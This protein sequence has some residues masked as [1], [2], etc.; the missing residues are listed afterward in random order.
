MAF[1]SFTGCESQE[2]Q[3]KHCHPKVFQQFYHILNIFPST[4][5]LRDSERSYKTTLAIC[6]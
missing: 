6:E 1:K 2:H 5:E 4:S 3:S